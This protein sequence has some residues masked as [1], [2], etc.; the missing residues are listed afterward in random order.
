MIDLRA[1][2]TRVFL[3]H[4]ANATSDPGGAMDAV[5]AW[6]SKD[7]STGPYANLRVRDISVTPDG[8]GGLFVTVVCSLG[9]VAEP[10]GAE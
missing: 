10:V 2:D 9:R 7:R 1:D 4:S 8:Q 3:F 6:L 5:N